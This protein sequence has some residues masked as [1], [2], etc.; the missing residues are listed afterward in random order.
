MKTATTAAIAAIITSALLYL[1]VP[2]RAAQPRPTLYSKVQA[3]RTLRAA[4]LVGAPLFMINP[5]TKEKSGT[6]YEVVESVAKKL[7]L[8]VSWTEEVGYGEMIQGLNSHRYDIVGSGVWINADRGK[9]ADFTIPVYYDG[10]CAYTRKDDTRFDKDISILNAPTYK[11]STMDGELGAAIATQDFPQAQTVGLPQNSDFS[12]LMFNVVNNKADIV[13][14]AVAPARAYLAK[15]PGTLREVPNRR[16]RV[17]AISIIL[18]KGEYELKQSLDY[19]L[20]EMLLSGDVET[21]L[22]KYEKAFNNPPGSFIRT[23][24]PYMDVGEQMK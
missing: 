22:V 11:I 5:N 19:A 12:Q 16:L 1:F 4:Y 23:A 8:R 13:F 7:G 6:F 2:T 20:S 17:F 9:D 18:P 21:I 10:V 3:N 14:V 24:L 15:N